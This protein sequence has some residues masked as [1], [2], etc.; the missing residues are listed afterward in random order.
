MILTT[1]WR[2][3]AG[4]QAAPRHGRVAMVASG[5]RGAQEPGAGAGGSPV[6]WGEVPP[7]SSHVQLHNAALCCVH[8]LV[9]MWPQPPSNTPR[10]GNLGAV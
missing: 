3:R 6:G 8:G 4:C 7:A 1:F 2:C 9:S 10:G 5:G